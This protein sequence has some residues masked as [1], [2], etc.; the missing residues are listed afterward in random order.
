MLLEP[1]EVAG[2]GAGVEA[3]RLGDESRGALLPLL[4][5]EDREGEEGLLKE[6]PRVR[7][8]LLP[9]LA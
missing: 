7:P 2:A 6:P 9:L 4:G 5:L 8:P 3:G 1:L